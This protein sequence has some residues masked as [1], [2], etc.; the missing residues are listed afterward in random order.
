MCLHGGGSHDFSG[1]KAEANGGTNEAIR[2]LNAALAYRA[3]E[4]FRWLKATPTSGVALGTVSASP[5][6]PMLQSDFVF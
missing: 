1:H 6:S 4:E 2:H 3:R 5:I